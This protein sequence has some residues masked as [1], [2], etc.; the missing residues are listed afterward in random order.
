[1]ATSRKTTAAADEVEASEVDT[2]NHNTPGDKV[3]MLSLRQDG[4]PDQTDPEIVIPRDDAV[5]ATTKQ[6]GARDDV[7][8]ADKAA[9]ALVDKHHKG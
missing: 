5:E 1:M 2:S 3:A 7:D 6:L 9:A 8:D 4:T